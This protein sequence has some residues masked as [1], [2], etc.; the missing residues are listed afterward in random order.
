MFVDYLDYI[1][2]HIPHK[3]NLPPRRSKQVRSPIVVTIGGLV[4]SSDRDQPMI[5][6]RS[7]E[8]LACKLSPGGGGGSA[9]GGGSGGV[10]NSQDSASQTSLD[11]NANRVHPY[12][13]Q[14]SANK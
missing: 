14:G 13:K 2:R 4:Q 8:T 7:L 5:M 3:V 10:Q 9:G 6:L 1:F 12:L 11:T